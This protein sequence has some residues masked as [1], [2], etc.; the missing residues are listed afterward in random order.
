VKKYLLIDGYNIIFAWKHLS[1][2]ANENL[3][4]A[5]DK[6]IGILSD[7]S[8]FTEEQIILVF[9]A[10]KVNNGFETVTT[11]NKVKIVYTKERETADSY[12]EK[13]AKVISLNYKVRVATADKIESL[14]ILGYGATPLSPEFLLKEVV[15]FKKEVKK[16]AEKQIKNNLLTDNI[17]KASLELLE[18]MRLNK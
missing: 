5:R 9:D 16:L 14:I 12:I 2:I 15:S 6:L 1:K 4:E 11:Y 10:Y 18:K 17:D 13:V 7:F 8:G 3:E